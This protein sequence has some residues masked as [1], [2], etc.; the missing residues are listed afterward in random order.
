MEWTYF[1]LLG[2][3]I[4]GFLVV[5]SQ[6]SWT[7]VEPGTL[8]IL[9]ATGFAVGSL[10]GLRKGRTWLGAWLGLFLGMAG[11]VVVALLPPGKKP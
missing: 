5:L 3:G 11:W 10:V 4:P 9:A 8:L 1:L 2:L 7:G 6:D